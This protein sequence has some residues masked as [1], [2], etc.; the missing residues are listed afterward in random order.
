MSKNEELRQKWAER[1]ANFRAS[2]QT[3]TEWCAANDI[4]VNQLRYWL[5]KHKKQEEENSSDMATPW[6]SV[7]MEHLAGAS[8][9][10]VVKIGKAVLEVKPGFNKKLLQEVVSALTELC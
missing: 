5:R 3:T 8:G 4:K 10:V 6:L 9:S 2:G 1:V 7:G